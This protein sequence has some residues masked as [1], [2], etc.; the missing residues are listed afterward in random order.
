M[1]GFM[2]RFDP[3]YLELKSQLGPDGVG[4]PLIVRN[5]HR[6]EIA[7]YGLD[8]ALSLTNAAIHEIDIN[9]WLTDD[10][11]AWVQVLTGRSGPLTPQGQHDP[12]F[13]LLQTTQG[14]IVEIEMFVQSQLGYEVSCHVTAGHGVAEMSD[15]AFV[16]TMQARHR[17]HCPA[18]AVAR[19]VPGGLPPA[20]AGVDHPPGHRES[21]AGRLGLGRLRRHHHRERGDRLAALR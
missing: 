18:G 4:D 5:T 2:R 19:S 11:Y 16:T 12:L 7:P 17:G 9:R 13:V 1:M 15:G 3:G 20:A 21:D 14:T 6:N 10:E 8:S